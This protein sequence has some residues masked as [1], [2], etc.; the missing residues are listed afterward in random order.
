[1]NQIE[2]FSQSLEEFLLH[3]EKKV[4]AIKGEWGIG[5]TYFWSNFIKKSSYCQEKQYSYVSLFGIS[6]LNEVQSAIFYNSK[7]VG[8]TNKQDSIVYG[9]K[10]ISKHLKKIPQISKFT[11]SASTIERFLLKDFLVCIDDIERK[12]PSLTISKL[13]GFIS[14]LSVENNCKFILIFNGDSF[15][16]EEKEEYAKYREKVVD[17]ELEYNPSI[18][19]N[20]E[21]VFKNH[22]HK[23]I[24]YKTLN[25][26]RLRNIRILNHI[27]WN[28]E[29]I[30]R[31]LNSIEKE[32]LNEIISTTALLT[33]LHCYL[34]FVFSVNPFFLCHFSLFARN[35]NLLLVIV[36]I[37][38]PF[39]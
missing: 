17:I 15:G 16:N 20:Q 2:Q 14:S 21:I 5:K 10:A 30:I 4:L 24:I 38:F 18:E 11:D 36:F 13:L 35:V 25:S 6:N 29:R 39:N 8:I 32:V 1:M 33:Y 22:Q 34:L 26:L 19:H 23:D 37:H 31:D 9:L 7:K 27:K 12:D 28:I 3:D